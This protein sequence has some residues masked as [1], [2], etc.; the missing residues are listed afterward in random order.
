[1]NAINTLKQRIKAT[2]LAIPYIA[3]KHVLGGRTSSQSDESQVLARIIAAVGCV[4]NVFI[5][6]GFSGW[7]FNCIELARER[8]W[9]GLLVDGDGYN[10]AIARTIFHRG[11][12][13]KKLWITL[14]TLQQII[15]YA[16]GREVGVLSID[17]DGN[18]FWF[19]QRL[20]GLR[21]A[22]ISLE[23]N[24]FFG[25]RP[26]TVPYDPEFDRMKKHPSGG[27][28]GAS[29]AAM[30]HMCEQYGYSLVAMSSNAVNAFFVRNDRLMPALMPLDPKDAYREQVMPDGTVVSVPPVWEQLKDMPYVDVTKLTAASASAN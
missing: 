16:R 21:P 2:P 5:E 28:F 13:A 24:T 7:E 26:I 29:L 15:D 30:H 14:E 23:V 18:D 10:A 25:L 1:M 27:Y 3:A 9:Q 12:Q 4:P 20:I 22:I 11:I 6:F 17:V 8:S 19:L